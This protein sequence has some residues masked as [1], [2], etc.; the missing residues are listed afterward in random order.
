MKVCPEKAL[1]FKDFKFSNIDSLNP[2]VERHSRGSFWAG[3]RPSKTEAPPPSPPLSLSLAASSGAFHTVQK[4]A[5]PRQYISPPRPSRTLLAL[6]LAISSKDSIG[7]SSS[8]G[9]LIDWLAICL[10][11]LR[12]RIEMG[13]LTFPGARKLFARVVSILYGCA[14]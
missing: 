9:H 8:L 2:S 7:I 1:L 14:Q 5:L 12:M 11:L 3:R 6:P 13:Q 4:L 10:W